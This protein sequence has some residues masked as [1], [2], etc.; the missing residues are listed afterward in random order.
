MNFED[1]I[2]KLESIIADI[3][4]AISEAEN[5]SYFEYKVSA[6]EEDLSELNERLHELEAKQ[7]KEWEA[8][9]RQRE[10]EYWGAVI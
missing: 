7:N 8:D 10:N 1:E 9:N 3:K 4:S 2:E 5:Y 6:W